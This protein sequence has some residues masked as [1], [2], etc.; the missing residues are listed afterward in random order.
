MIYVSG[1][2]KMKIKAS[3]EAGGYGPDQILGMPSVGGNI[4]EG[5][6]CPEC[7][8]FKTELLQAEAGTDIYWCN[9]CQLRFSV[10][11]VV[12]DGTNPISQPTHV[13]GRGIG[14]DQ[15]ILG[16]STFEKRKSLSQIKTESKGK[17]GEFERIARE[18]GYS[19]EEVREFLGMSNKAAESQYDLDDTSDVRMELTDED[20]EKIKNEYNKDD[21]KN[22]PFAICTA[23][24]GRD[25]AKYESC[26]QHLKEQYGVKEANIMT[27][28][29]KNH[30][31]DKEE[32]MDEVEKEDDEDLSDM[33]EE[34]KKTYH[35]LRA[36]VKKKMDKGKTE[37]GDNPEEDTASATDANS[38]ITP[39]YSTPS[40]GQHIVNPPSGIHDNRNATGA[41]SPS[42]VS[43]S[44]KEINPEFEKSP[45]AR[46]LRE[47]RK[48]IDKLRKEKN[49]LVKEVIPNIVSERLKGMQSFNKAVKD[50]FGAET[51]NRKDSLESD[52][53]LTFAKMNS[54]S[55][56]GY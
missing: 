24:V 2:I 12:T 55:R 51:L 21:A 43:Y 33:D 52:G 45:L 17:V 37:S 40:A 28:I 49:E 8:D 53:P 6:K 48:E 13:T 27:E 56:G 30:S 5:Q 44:G 34:E 25:S 3:G 46:E 7:G 26:V 31:P 23:A 16:K 15:K 42:E 32:E 10:E 41:G 14:E 18:E 38:S 35:K 47:L 22:N 19:R 36:K 39:G 4:I 1:G 50:N 9:T 54:I 11:S 20:F 29:N